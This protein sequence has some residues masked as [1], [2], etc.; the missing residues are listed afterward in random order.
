MYSQEMSADLSSV[1]HV[2][3]AHRVRFWFI[4]VVFFLFFV[5]LFVFG[6]GGGAHSIQKFWASDSAVSLTARS[7]RNSH[8]QVFKEYQSL[9]Q[10][11][12]YYTTNI[13]EI[14][15]ILNN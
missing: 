11:L 7:P 3:T 10:A 9:Q 8:G 15:P 6:G 4:V 5:C 1:L 14:V 2:A 13:I 12:K